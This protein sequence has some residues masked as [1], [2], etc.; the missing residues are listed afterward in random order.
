MKTILTA[1]AFFCFSSLANAI[2]I[3]ATDSGWYNNGG[4]HDASNQ[5]YIAGTEGGASYRNFFVFDTSSI[6]GQVTAATL[7]IN[8]AQVNASGSYKLYDVT[9]SL[10]SLLAGGNGLNATYSDL[11]S[12]ISFGTIDIHAAQDYQIINIALNSAGLAALN[13]TTGLFAIGG[14]YNSLY[15]FAFSHNTL[16]D[17]HLI[18]ETSKV[19]EPVSLALLGLGLLGVAATR[20]RKQA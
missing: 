17:R 14:A 12:G 2:T 6:V 7:R 9:T 15:S 5:N 13:A 3:T 19:P 18:V 1:L 11:G 16:A 10:P 4:Q 8:T 20:R